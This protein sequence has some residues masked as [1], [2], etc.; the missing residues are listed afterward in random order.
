MGYYKRLETQ[1]RD[2]FYNNLPSSF[3]PQPEDEHYA[4]LKR[5]KDGNV[6]VIHVDDTHGDDYDNYTII[7]ISGW[8]IDLFEDQDGALTVRV[9]HRGG[10]EPIIVDNTGT[11][12]FTYNTPQLIDKAAKKYK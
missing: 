12:Q 5:L 10:E 9:K 4:M 7:Q 8:D 3:G 6:K 11:T 2:D 1:S